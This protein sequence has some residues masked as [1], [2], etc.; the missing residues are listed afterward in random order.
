[1]DMHLD[2]CFTCES[3]LP[4]MGYF[5]GGCL[6]QFKCKSCDTELVKD[7]IGCVNCGTPKF[8]KGANKEFNTFRLSETLTER[9]IE[10]SFTDNVAR[11]IADLIKNNSSKNIGVSSVPI[12]T[13]ETIPE[14]KELDKESNDFFEVLGNSNLHDNNEIAQKKQTY[15]SLLAVAMKNLASSDVEWLVLFS[16]FA[17]NF[18]A[19][20]FS[21]EQIFNKYKEGN[22]Y[23][24]EIVARFSRDIQRAVQREF[25]NPLASGYSMLDKGIEKA[26]EILAR[27]SSS[28]PKLSKKSNTKNDVPNKVKSISQPKIKADEF[29]PYIVKPNLFDFFNGV[30][31]QTSSDKLLTIGYYI[32]KV[33]KTGYFSD[34]NVDFAYKLLKIDRPNYLRQTI[35]NINNKEFWLELGV[36]EK[37]WKLT[38]K[39][40]IHF[41]ETLNK[42]K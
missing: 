9:N 41:E 22:K 34:G 4:S 30:N 38:R 21:K 27:T 37:S 13:I 24:K 42:D 18:G 25:I 7:A 6:T 36:V 10:A 16:F 29:D 14:K 26:S 5:C 12:K 28:S 39:G 15:P 23:T 1:M 2:T 3:K 17:S 19:N 20:E 11:E 31:P 35:S 40:E 8:E 32:D 33:M